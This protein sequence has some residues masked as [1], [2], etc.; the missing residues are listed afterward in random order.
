VHAAITIGYLERI[1]RLLQVRY[2][3]ADFRLGDYFD[4]IGGVGPSSLLALELARGR[5]VTE[6]ADTFKYVLEQGFKKPFLLPFRLALF[7]PLYS[8]GP[9]R[10]ALEQRFGNL[11]LTDAAFATG[12]ALITTS[13]AS[14]RPVVISNHPALVSELGQGERLAGVAFAC[15]ARPGYF[16]PAVVLDAHGHQQALVEGEASIGPDPS[17][18]LLLLAT[19][20][21][22]PFRWRIGQHRLFMT[23]VGFEK[24]ATAKSAT[25]LRS[26]SP[27]IAIGR[28]LESLSV[29]AAYQSR[30]VLEALAIEAPTSEAGLLEQS[31]AV[32]Y[33]RYETGF[34]AED[35]VQFGLPDMG[36]LR[37]AQRHES[38][39]FDRFARVGRAAAARH[40]VAGHFPAAFDVRVPVET[41]PTRAAEAER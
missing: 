7:R 11:R 25:E 39:C 5:S 38:E 22:F 30:M 20:P 24:E 19:S 33:R 31:A 6:A 41:S 16:T 34:E 12:F 35:L 3:E 37:S 36:E 21:H 18:A 40:I 15:L 28:L 10:Q 1:E 17:L 23:A 13:L 2:G 9:L 32:T 29:G 14:A 27:L 4:L 8:D 26:G